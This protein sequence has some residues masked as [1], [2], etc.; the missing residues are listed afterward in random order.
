M[1]VVLDTNVWISELALNSSRGA[2]VRFYLKRTGAVLVIPEV[3]RLEIEHNLKSTLSDLADRAAASHRQ[4]LS[5]FG[6]L[7]E[8]VLPTDDEIDTKVEEIV[9]SMDVPTREVEFTMDVARSALIRVIDKKPPS[10]KSQQFKD[11]VIWARC[12]KL[13][14]ED[15]VCLVTQDKGFYK[16]RDYSQGLAPSLQ[17]E[18]AV[19]GHLLTIM[20]DVALL[21]DVMRS[22]VHIEEKR[23]VEDYMAKFSSSME[24]MLDWAGFECEGPP[25]VHAKLYAT[26]NASRLYIE[27]DIQY[28]CA[29]L[30]E[31]GR[32]DASL[33][34]PGDGIY[35]D[36]SGSFVELRQHGEQL[37][38]R[39]EEGEQKL[40]H[41]VIHC[42]TGIFGHRTVRYTVREPL[43]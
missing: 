40:E 22:D 4:L 33:R 37:S 21:L 11:C 12:I 19:A 34:L 7:K 1:L 23:L 26:E 9:A 10:D 2:A 3:I 38:Y 39:D 18:T 41:N 28:S 25:Q 16:G 17:R 30:T 27:F 14:E 6:N 42:G 36:P 5:V 13:L 24:A 31:E 15:D 43:G 35:D 20:Q 32:A 29:D 8:V